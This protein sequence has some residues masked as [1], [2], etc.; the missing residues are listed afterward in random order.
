M[1]DTLLAHNLPQAISLQDKLSQARLNLRQFE[2]LHGDTDA[3]E[4]A[5]PDGIAN[6][7]IPSNILR[8]EL[9]I[10]IAK[11]EDRLKQLGVDA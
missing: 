5:Y 2:R 11:L 3:I 7:S 10:V 4:V 9:K 1:R 6:V 8:I